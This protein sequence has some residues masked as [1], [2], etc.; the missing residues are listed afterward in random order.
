MKNNKMPYN[1]K[2]TM[3]WGDYGAIQKPIFPPCRESLFDLRFRVKGQITV[4][5]LAPYLSYN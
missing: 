4:E 2:E 5:L 1:H 3:L